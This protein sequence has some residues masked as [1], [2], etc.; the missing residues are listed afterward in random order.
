MLFLSA[1]AGLTFCNHQ[2]Q[3]KHD[4]EI[5]RLQAERLGY[6]LENPAERINLHSSL[7]EI[8]GLALVREGVLACVQ[9]ELGRVYF[10]DIIE[11]KIINNIKFA[12]SGD[13]EGIE[14]VDNRIYV[15]ESN[16]TLYTFDLPTEDEKKVQANKIKTPLTLKNDVEGLGFLPDSDKLLIACKGQAGIDGAKVKGKAIYAYDLQENRFETQPF[17][18]IR[19]S[20][21][22]KFIKNNLDNYTIKKAPD[23]KPSGIAVHPET[24]KIY[25]LNSVGKLLLVLDEDGNI[26]DMAVLNPK[27]FRQPEGICFSPNGD[28]YIASEGVGG[29]GYILVFNYLR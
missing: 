16:G 24:H 18:S 29:R 9:D 23:F 12:R 5:I 25:L 2:K 13:Y 20:D 4:P 8:S 26:E 22:T 17:F 1:L 21:I 27:T 11:K 10:Y 19:K 6:D 3:K 28:L 15:V 14:L 7:R